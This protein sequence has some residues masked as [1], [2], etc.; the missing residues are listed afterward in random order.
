[1]TQVPG[2]LPI[3]QG[4][5]AD[6]E[7]G[8]SVAD[9]CLE[10][11][12][13]G[14]L[15]TD[16]EALARRFDTPLLVL[17]PGRLTDAYQTLTA[18]LPGVSLHYAVKAFPHASA[19]RV[20]DGL[21]ASF[22][23]ASVG[24]L[25]LVADAG[26]GAQRVIYTHPIKR[27]RD[28]ERALGFGCETV[29]V[30]NTEELLKLLPF[31][32]QLDVLVRVSFRNRDARVDLSRK[33]GCDPEDAERLIQQSVELGIRVRGLAFNVGSQVGGANAYVQ[34]ID[35]CRQLIANAPAGVQM[36]TLDIGGGFPADYQGG[37]GSMVDFCAPIREALQRMPADVEIVA[38][39]GRS[40]VAGAVT[41]ITSV[42][43]KSWRQGRLWY[44]LDD[45]LYGSYSGRVY[46][47]ADSRFLTLKRGMELPSVLAGPTCDSFD[48]LAEDVML[49]ELEV[50]DLIISPMMGAYTSASASDFNSLRRARVVSLSVL[51]H[52]RASNGR[53]PVVAVS[54]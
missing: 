51:R 6:A 22:D 40:L 3:L 14:L 27:P 25:D 47:N 34:A 32:E 53:A 9:E 35:W 42:I 44:Y 17:D 15:R 21:G 41:L 45:G 37:L 30:D 39:P 52:G 16:I 5:V 48:L 54:P 1:M 31:R 7:A 49:P 18:A 43:G 50:G 26:V 23:V 13:A 33:F 29:V 46:D 10:V 12:V 2:P 11:R 24:E 36:R 28:I 4:S 8:H 38:E 20:L 19:I